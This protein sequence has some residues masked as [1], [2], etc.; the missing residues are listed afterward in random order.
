[1]AYVRKRGTKWLVGW[2]DRDGANR[3][4]SCPTAE[5][6]KRL[7]LEVETAHALGRSWGPAERSRLPPE[8]PRFGHLMRGYL[9]EV[10]ALRAPSTA[11]LKAM[12]IDV[13]LGFLRETKRDPDPLASTLTRA[14]LAEYFASLGDRAA[15]TKNRYVREVEAVWR[16]GSEQSEWRGMVPPPVKLP[17]PKASKGKTI[18]PTWAEMDACILACLDTW[19]ARKGIAPK[20]PNV[21][22]YRLAVVLR[23]TGLRVAQAMALRWED[24]DLRHA[25]MHVTTGKSAQEKAGRVVPVSR[26]LVA[27]MAGWGRREG[28]VVPTHRKAD[29]PRARI[30]RQQN[31]LRAWR[32]AG[33]REEAWQGRS[34]HSFRK[35][36][37]S[38][39]RRLGADP[40]AIEVLVG[41]DT[42]LRGIYTDAT[43]LPLVETVA[44]IPKVQPVTASLDA[45][46]KG[47]AS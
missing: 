22:L 33:V 28:W 29:G 17:L 27:E 9:A 30:A 15:S 11:A 2:R 43:A 14:L 25:T 35:G 13:F 8:P 4:R 41:H 40:D 6:A 38:G 44:L 21:A 32:R 7:R 3:T 34:H 23:Y 36:F 24:I 19:P 26:H 12:Q 31:M 20:S 16:W 1:M 18:A 47:G 37:V 45:A 5:A 46:R 10:N 42:G 39:L